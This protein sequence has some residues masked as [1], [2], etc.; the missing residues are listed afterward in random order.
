MLPETTRDCAKS[1]TNWAWA[2][3]VFAVRQGWNL[4]AGGNLEEV[5]EAFEKVNKSMDC[6]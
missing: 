2:L 4:I 3:S 5:T 6:G 1:I